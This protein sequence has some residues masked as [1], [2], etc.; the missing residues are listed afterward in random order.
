MSSLPPST[1]TASTGVDEQSA[2]GGE[3]GGEESSSHSSIQFIESTTLSNG[4]IAG[5]SI[6]RPQASD[7]APGPKLK[8]SKPATKKKGATTGKGKGRGVEIVPT[9]PWPEE[10]R[11][12]EKIFKVCFPFFFRFVLH[13][14]SDA[15]LEGGVG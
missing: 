9:L 1:P 13:F 2:G 11:D 8:K 5:G 10:F 6:K 15:G 3:G 7:E 4:S 12:L 14:P